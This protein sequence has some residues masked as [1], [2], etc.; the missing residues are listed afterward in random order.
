MQTILIIVKV[1]KGT[2]SMSTLTMMAVTMKTRKMTAKLPEMRSFWGI[3]K[4]NETKQDDTESER[5][6]FTCFLTMIRTKY[7][8]E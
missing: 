3:L 8:L 7:V 6:S 1:K 5:K 4:R 2:G